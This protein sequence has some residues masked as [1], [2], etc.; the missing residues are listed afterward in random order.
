[1]TTV[2]ETTGEVYTTRVVNSLNYRHED[3]PGLITTQ[4]SLTIP[5]QT[6]SLREIVRRHVRGLPIAGN[7]PIYQM[8]EETGEGLEVP[9][10]KAMDISEVQEYKQQINDYVTATRAKLTQEQNE[11]ER[12]SNE[13][14][15]KR[16]NEWNKFQEYIKK[17]SKDE[18]GSEAE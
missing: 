9:N 8:D 3:Y 13:K 12:I 16:Q 10:L 4:P 6:Q 11:R 17:Q 18:Q 5:D 14:R 2:N 15:T 7:Q 1:M